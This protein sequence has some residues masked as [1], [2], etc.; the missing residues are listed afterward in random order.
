[1]P[2][3]MTGA[4]NWE[5]LSNKTKIVFSII[6]NKTQS[7]F[8]LENMAVPKIRIMV[9]MLEKSNRENYHCRMKWR[10]DCLDKT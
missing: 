10:H 2:L 9:R 6:V 5:S 1:M 8:V 4:R 3:M 7:T